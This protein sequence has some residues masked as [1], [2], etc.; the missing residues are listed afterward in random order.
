MKVQNAIVGEIERIGIQTDQAFTIKFDAKMA[1]IL[2]DGLY[3]D[4]V[5]SVIRELS[6]NAWDSHVEAGNMN[7]PFEVHIP[8]TIEPWF[9]VKDYGVGLTHEQVISIY[10]CYGASTKTNSNAVIGQLGL[11]SKSPFSICNAFDV[12][13]RKDGVENHYSMYKDELGMPSVAHLG[14]SPTT[15]PNGVTV[16]MPVHGEQRREFTDK[17]KEVFKWFA[18]KPIVQGIDGLVIEQ[19]AYSYEG[20][21]W[22]IRKPSKDHYGYYRTGKP[23]ALMGMVAYPLD[24]NS[25]PGLDDSYTMLMDMPL[26]LRFEIGD[27]EVAANREALGYDSRTCD[28]IKARLATLVTELGQRFEREISTA[29]TLWQAKKKFNDIF[30]DGD[31]G[32]QFR[33]VFGNTGLN[34]NGEVIKSNSHSFTI[35]ENDKVHMFNEK[36]KGG[37]RVTELN[38]S[39][40]CDD[41]TV[42]MFND[43]KIGGVG[44]AK[45]YHKEHDH[46]KVIWLF[47]EAT[48][49][50]K[51]K[52]DLGNPP[53]VVFTST[54][55]K[56]V[57]S[58]SDR[59]NTLR[60]R[61]IQTESS[62]KGWEQVSIDLDEGGYYVEISSWDVVGL[63]GNDLGM[64]VRTAKAAGIIASD[65]KIYAMRAGNKKIVR[66]SDDWVELLAYVKEET[67]KQV[68]AN[69]LAQVIADS[70]EFQSVSSISRWTMWKNLDS[71]KDHDGV[72]YKFAAEAA[73]MY[74]SVRQIGKNCDY[75]RSLA[76]K[77][78]IA[79]DTVTPR[80]QLRDGLNAVF[81]AYPMLTFGGGWGSYG[82]EDVRKAIN[83][84]NYVDATK[85]FYDLND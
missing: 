45:L 11:G 13:S 28:N 29:A 22:A 85:T 21:D 82:D 24:L 20:K 34:W 5:Q 19:I 35:T 50:E 77:L 66:E 55:P 60:W 12:S 58:M 56:P 64:I 18:V 73:E 49:L 6:C 41:D 84:V 9:S 47:S 42:I 38:V 79:L 54:L 48:D 14:S 1:K 39:L 30:G 81:K 78:G 61:E 10:T 37:R 53:Q 43:L 40:T 71:F 26:V 7:Q 83:Y 74:E 76:V 68:K 65:A 80:Y 27:L 2:A 16:K 17:A 75:L 32:R 52:N 63:P 62:M 59:T 70:E 4:K 3:S 23:V 51:I 72:M 8:N 33:Q 25:I 46:D 67:A 57:G 15:E 69:N 36:Y 31:Y 44:R